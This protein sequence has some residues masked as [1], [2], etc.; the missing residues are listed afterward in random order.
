MSTSGMS[1]PKLPVNYNSKDSN[2]QTLNIL[3]VIHVCCIQSSCLS[4]IYVTLA[5]P[6]HQELVSRGEEEGHSTRHSICRKS[7]TWVLVVSY[8]MLP[9]ADAVS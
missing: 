5:L 4:D 9:D 3:G 8:S 1:H 7:C 6:H 2:R